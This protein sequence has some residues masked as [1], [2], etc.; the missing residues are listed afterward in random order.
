MQLWMSETDVPAGDMWIETLIEKAVTARVM[1]VCLTPENQ[2]SRWLHFEVG[3]SMGKPLIPLLWDLDAGDVQPPLGTFNCCIADRRG[4]WKLVNRL[5]EILSLPDVK[6]DLFDLYW[7]DLLKEINAIDELHERSISPSGAY[8]GHL[9]SIGLTPWVALKYLSRLSDPQA[10]RRFLDQ[11]RAKPRASINLLRQ[12]A[13]GE[14]VRDAGS[15]MYRHIMWMFATH[16]S[17]DYLNYAWDGELT[18]ASTTILTI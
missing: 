18:E 2:D 17:L 11:S 5:S 13:E 12:F 15:L 8:T 4:I 6:H 7:P 14:A 1:L 10:K 16:S 3:L 9:T